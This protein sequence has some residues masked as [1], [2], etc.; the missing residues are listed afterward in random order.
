MWNFDGNNQTFLW[1]L[2]DA[3]HELTLHKVQN[4]NLKIPIGRWKSMAK[5]HPRTFQ[6]AGP[7]TIWDLDVRCT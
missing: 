4:E 7:K 1:M 3:R 5:E 6:S 2:R